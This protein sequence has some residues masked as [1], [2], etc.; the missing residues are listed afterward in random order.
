V[1]TRSAGHPGTHCQ[2]GL[3]VH[4]PGPLLEPHQ[5]GLG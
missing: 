3:L 5:R 4:R 1:R 2:Y